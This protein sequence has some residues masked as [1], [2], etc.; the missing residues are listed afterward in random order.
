MRKNLFKK[1]SGTA[2]TLI[3][4]SVI[5]VLISVIVAGLVSISAG[6]IANQ[7]AASGNDNIAM[8]YRTLGKYLIANKKLP[9]PASLKEVKSSSSTYGT[10]ISATDCVGAGVYQSTTSTNLVYGMAPTQ[11]LG[12]SDDF[13]EDAY[14]NK[15]IYVV[16]KRL[17]TTTGDSFETNIGNSTLITISGN[18]S[19]TNAIFILM[20]RGANSSG[21]YAANFANAP[22]ASSDSNELSNDASGINDGVSPPTSTFDGTFIKSSSTTFDDVVFYTTKDLMFDDFDAWKIIPCTSASSTE[23]LYGTSFTWP[24]AYGQQ[25]VAATTVCPANWTGG[26]TYPTKK[27][28]FNGA[29]ESVVNPC[30]A[31]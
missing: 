22:A 17:T 3:E 11:T 8:I 13:G 4:L 26:V 7:K 20:S 6:K 16:D 23:T 14:A 29:W 27:C 2:F 18:A 28:G 30:I 25:V 10:A 9:C 5:I 24:K 31:N 15:I 1:K 21:A 19:L 12:L